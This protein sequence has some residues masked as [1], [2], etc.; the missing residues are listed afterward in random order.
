MFY[1]RVVKG[2]Q[3]QHARDVTVMVNGTSYQT[4]EEGVTQIPLS[5]PGLYDIGV[6]GH[7]SETRQVNDEGEVVRMIIED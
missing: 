7:K 1:V 6:V 5:P 4:N 2:Q 3:K